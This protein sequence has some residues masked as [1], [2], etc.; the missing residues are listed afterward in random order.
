MKELTE[1]LEIECKARKNDVEEL[2]RQRRPQRLAD[3]VK[4]GEIS[5]YIEYR[6]S[7]YNTLKII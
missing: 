3:G 7:T 5:R 4:S 2:R 6:T 1:L